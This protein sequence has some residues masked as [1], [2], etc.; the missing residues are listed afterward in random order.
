[1]RKYL[2]C[3]GLVG[4]L[5]SCNLFRHTKTVTD[6]MHSSQLDNTSFDFLE[7]KDWLSQ[8]GNYAFDVHTNAADYRIQFWPKGMFTY[9]P[10]TGFKGEAD[11]VVLIG[12]AAGNKIA[13]SSSV[14]AEQDKG[15]L[16]TAYVHQE[17]SMVD[18][19][20][21]QKS[22]SPSWKIILPVCCLV[23]LVL[24]YCIFK[25]RKLQFKL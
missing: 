12:S 21:K 15:K 19:A 17:K 9:S 10:E 14:L 4:L 23:L 3:L 6:K 22:T 2:C 13:I 24:A 11:S 7:E 25:L 16:K 20:E 5:W 8:S 1:M 18:L